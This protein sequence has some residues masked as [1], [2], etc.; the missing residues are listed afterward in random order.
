MPGDLP[1]LQM[2][3]HTVLHTPRAYPTSYLRE[4]IHAI[5]SKVS[6]PFQPKNN[7]NGKAQSLEKDLL[8]LRGSNINKFVIAFNED[9]N[10]L[11][12]YD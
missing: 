12:S 11:F 4:K 3:M 7:N 10:K 6:S 2:T 1:S 5:H 9:G 8:F